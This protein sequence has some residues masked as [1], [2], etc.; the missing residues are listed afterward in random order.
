MLQRVLVAALI[1]SSGAPL[2]E[3]AERRFVVHDVPW[4]MY[5]ALRD[6]LDETGVRMTYLK[7]PLE[8]MSPSALHEES[9]KLL[10][11]CSKCAPKSATSTSELR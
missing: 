7:G 6:E 3:Q 8:L 1:Q 11:R 9:K 5:V 10:A 4:W 2:A